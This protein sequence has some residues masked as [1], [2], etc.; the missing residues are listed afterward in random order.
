VAVSLFNLLDKVME[1]VTNIVRR[2]LNAVLSQVRL[3][4]A[5]GTKQWTRFLSR[6]NKEVSLVDIQD[7][8]RREVRGLTFLRQEYLHV[9]TKDNTVRGVYQTKNDA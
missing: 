9:D 5:M 1:D 7:A 3:S 2:M 6:I 4:R 8:I